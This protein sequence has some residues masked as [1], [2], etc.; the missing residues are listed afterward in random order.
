M[1]RDQIRRMRIEDKKVPVVP[2]PS[3]HAH[4]LGRNEHADVRDKFGMNEVFDVT[5]GAGKNL[6]RLARPLVTRGAEIKRN[7]ERWGIQPI[8]RRKEGDPGTVTAEPA[9]AQLDHHM[10]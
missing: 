10:G 7:E 4:R 1:R 8:I 3:P 6:V 5:A 2:G 9:P